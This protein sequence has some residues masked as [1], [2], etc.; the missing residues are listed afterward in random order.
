MATFAHPTARPVVAFQRVTRAFGSRVALLDCSVELQ[1]GVV[2]LLGPNGAGKTTWLNL[3]AGLVA[4][5]SGQVRWLGELG[6]RDPGLDNRVN[7]C[8]D[9]DQMPRRLTVMQWL[10]GM[11]R[12]SGCPASYAW[13]RAGQMLDRLGLD[14]KKDAKLETLSRGQRQRVKIAQA[15]ALPATL[16]LLDEPLNALDPVWRREVAAL[17]HEAASA[18][19]CVV[20]SSH[21]LEEVEALASHLVL[22]FK[23]RL[24]AAGHQEDIRDL[25]HNQATLLKISCSD[26]RSLARELLAKAPVTLVRVDSAGNDVLTVQAADAE[27][28]CRALPHAVLASG[29]A[30]ERVDTQGDDLV[31][32]F[33]ALAAEVR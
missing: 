28:L 9:N 15:F 5:S 1:P 6:R 33:A 2:G 21:I 20:V 14:A 31:S 32:L 7:L 12:L 3:A 13:Q 18:G 26:A 22:L 19:A 27:A 16:L 8:T 11:L 25:L 30:V 4:P 17:M 24:V 29:V 23:G 10:T